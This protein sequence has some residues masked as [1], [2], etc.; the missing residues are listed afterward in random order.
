VK[1]AAGSS[2][3]GKQTE[4]HSAA[5]R[6]IAD[7][8]KSKSSATTSKTADSIRKALDQASSNDQS[9]K[10]TT[11][12]QWERF[13]LNKVN[14]EEETGRTAKFDAHRQSVLAAIEQ[15]SFT[16]ATASFHAFCG[17]VICTCTLE[18]PLDDFPLAC[19]RMYTT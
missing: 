7:M 11:T 5:A 3:H 1:S 10:S 8:L 17:L 9:S 19:E 6:S 13:D 18:R 16:I 15:V 14:Y 2:L 4:P 12:A